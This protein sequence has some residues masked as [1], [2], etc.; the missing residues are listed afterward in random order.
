MGCFVCDVW[1]RLSGL[2]SC[3]CPEANLSVAT[4]CVRLWTGLLVTRL[5]N[6]SGG[7]RSPMSSPCPSASRASPCWASITVHPL[8]TPCLLPQLAAQHP[9][10]HLG[11]HRLQRGLPA[12]S[13]SSP[14]P[15]LQRWKTRHVG[16]MLDEGRWGGKGRLPCAD[17]PPAK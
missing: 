17:D 12:Q 10:A 16:W 13:S 7:I 2:I 11:L 1:S 5:Y 3:L 9:A 6:M 4:Q 15:P 14:Q 8:I